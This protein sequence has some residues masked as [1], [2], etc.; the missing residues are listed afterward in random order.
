MFMCEEM[1][2]AVNVCN[3]QGQFNDYSSVLS[4]VANSLMFAVLML[5]LQSLQIV[6]KDNCQGG[7]QPHLSLL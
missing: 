6:F 1:G 4:L 5:D 7:S 3:I 2:K